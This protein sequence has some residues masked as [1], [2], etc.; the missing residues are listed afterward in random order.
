MGKLLAATCVLGL[1][2]L[3]PA[4]AIAQRAV[5]LVR[6]AEKQDDALSPN[7]KLQAGKLAV[8]LRDAGINAIYTTQIKRTKETAAPL[9]ALIEANGDTV[10]IE[11]LTLSGDFLKNIND[12]MRLDSYA[13]SAAKTVRQKSADEIVLII[14]H[15]NTVPAIIAAFGYKPKITIQNTEFDRLFLL[16]PK[17]N[18]GAATPGFLHIAHYAQ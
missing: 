5:Y 17:A 3:W 11:E 16:I 13:K 10:R 1:A 4:Q 18:G 2:A 8:L 7:G 12:E 14:G 15:D 9:K 6:H